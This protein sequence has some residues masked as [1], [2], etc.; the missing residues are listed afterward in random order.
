MLRAQRGVPGEK[1]LP[2]QVRVCAGDQGG[3]RTRARS[4]RW[5]AVDRRNGDRHDRAQPEEVEDGLRRP[6]AATRLRHSGAAAGRR[7]RSLAQR[8][9]RGQDAVRGLQPGERGGRVGD[10]QRHFRH[11]ADDFQPGR[12]EGPAQHFRQGASAR[13]RDHRQEAHR[14]R[15]LGKP[16]GE[17]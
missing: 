1:R 5:R 4:V 14:Q 2:P 3:A 17:A 8:Q 11:A 6:R 15:R 7:D 13:G 16:S 10:R 12:P 9:G